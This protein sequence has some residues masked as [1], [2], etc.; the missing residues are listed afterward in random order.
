MD[1]GKRT[2]SREIANYLAEIIEKNS[3]TPN[4]KLP[5]ESVLQKQFGVSHVPIRSAYAHLIERGLVINWHGKGY[6][7]KDALYKNTTPSLKKICFITPHMDA[8][9][10]RNIFKG[11][12]QFCDEQMLNVS[13]LPSDQS[14][15]KEQSLLQSLKNSDFKGLIIYPIDNEFYNEELLKL[16]MR[17]FPIVII[18]R[19]L[20]GVNISFIAMDNYN[21]M[22][23]AVK[24]LHDKK[25]KNIVYVAPPASL[26]TSE[27]ERINGFNHGLFKYYGVAKDINLL[28]IKPEDYPVIKQSLVKYLKEHPDTDVLIVTGKQATPALQAAADLNIPIPQ[29]LRL[30]IIDNEL[31][32]T[33]KAFVQPY[34]LHMDG[35]EMGRKAAAALYNQIYGNHHIISESL[36]TTIIDCSASK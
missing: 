35:Y 26:A 15:K 34:I 11:I 2:I 10:M 30:M 23:N 12:N 13:F 20:K 16:S 5:S 27:S 6:F 21:A 1:M 33:E 22:V 14:I 4:Y 31:S 17:H 36:P 25:H 19:N 9:F 24:F 29:K 28:K 32:E 7:I 3:G 8:L 18:D